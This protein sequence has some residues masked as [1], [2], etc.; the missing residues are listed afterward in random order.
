MT[1]LCTGRSGIRI[2]VGTRYF[3]LLQNVWTGSGSQLA[4]YPMGTGV[5][6]QG[7]LVVGRVKLSPSAQI[8]KLW[9]YNSNPLTCHHDVDGD[10]FNCTA[11]L[12]RLSSK[13]YTTQL[14]IKIVITYSEFLPIPFRN[15]T[16]EYSSYAG[17][18]SINIG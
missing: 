17:K 3:S 8:K 15:L 18:I 16:S 12:L 5:I 10:N 11:L 1:R 9:S 14:V 6:S 4:T 2:P 13:F 7:K